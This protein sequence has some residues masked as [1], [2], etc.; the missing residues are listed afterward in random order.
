MSS[1]NTE[2]ERPVNASQAYLDVFLS[3]FLPQTTDHRPLYLTR[4]FP[5]VIPLT[6]DGRSTTMMACIVTTVNLKIALESKSWTWVTHLTIWG[7]IAVYI[8]LW[9]CCLLSSIFH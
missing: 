6:A 8:F 7:S 4:V 2:I 9:S 1:G 3:A 5:P